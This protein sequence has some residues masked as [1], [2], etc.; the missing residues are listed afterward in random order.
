MN[1]VILKGN[2]GEDARLTKFESGGAVAQFS[3]ATSRKAIK[4]KDGREIPEQTQWH[5]VVI[6]R[7]AMAEALAPHIKK[8]TAVLVQGE[9][10]YRDWK[11]D[12]GVVHREAEVFASEFEFC[13]GKREQAPAPTPEAQPSE[14]PGGKPYD[15]NYDL[16][17]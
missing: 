9:L 3:L 13:G 5:R 15:P 6:A 4:T 7:S 12:S 11:D 10:R 1:I 17:W 8:G 16:P 14:Q 2:A